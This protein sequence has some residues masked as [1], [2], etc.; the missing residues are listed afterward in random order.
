MSVPTGTP[1]NLDRVP[2]PD[3]V[4]EIRIH[5]RALFVFDQLDEAA[6]PAP[7]RLQHRDGDVLPVLVRLQLQDQRQ[8]GCDHGDVLELLQQAGD[9]NDLFAQTLKRMIGAQQCELGPK[10][11]K[12]ELLRVEIVIG[13]P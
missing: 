7:H 11:Q 8:F 4:L 1:A 6:Q 2:C 9:R 5:D 3:L 12:V 10:E 13:K